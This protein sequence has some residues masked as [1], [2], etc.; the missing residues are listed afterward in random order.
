MRRAITGRASGRAR[1]FSTCIHPAGHEATDEPRRRISR[2]GKAEIVVGLV[3][4]AGTDLKQAAS[5]VTS[6]LAPY[7]YEVVPVRLSELMREIKGGGYLQ[8]IKH[9]DER[10]WSHMNAGDRS[11]GIHTGRCLCLN[12]A[13]NG[14]QGRYRAIPSPLLRRSVP[15]SNAGRVCDVPNTRRGPEIRWS[16]S[17]SFKTRSNASSYKRRDEE[18]R[19][20]AAGLSAAS[21]STREHRGATGASETGAIPDT[22]EPTKGRAKKSARRAR[23]S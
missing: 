1:S 20:G 2:P 9:E 10:I 14:A 12:P 17:L 13:A 15:D 21:S 6:A 16:S 11:R 8:S 7:G 18:W 5:A 4:A 19:S 23:E 22:K 3:G